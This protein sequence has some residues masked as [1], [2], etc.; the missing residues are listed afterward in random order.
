MIEIFKTTVPENT[1]A[2]EVVKQLL[3][4]MPGAK[5]SFDLE[6]CDRILRIESHSIESRFIYQVF[7]DLK[8]SCETLM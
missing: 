5:I 7:N 2:Q 4:K 1:L 3:T 8:I 6:D